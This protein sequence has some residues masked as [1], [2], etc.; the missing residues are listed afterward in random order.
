MQIMTVQPRPGDVSTDGKLSVQLLHIPPVKSAK[1]W[2][3]ETTD[4]ITR[5]NN[6]RKKIGKDVKLKNKWNKRVKYNKDKKLPIV[7]TEDNI[8]FKALEP[9][10]NVK[11]EDD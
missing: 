8:N 7:N 11:K 2:K 1:L 6:R 5:N 4:S 9:K 10:Y 3:K